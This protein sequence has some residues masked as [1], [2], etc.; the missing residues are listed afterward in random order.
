[1]KRLLVTGVS[2]GVGLEFIKDQLESGNF[3]YGVSRTKSDE[4]NEVS[5]KYP[6]SFHHFL[7]DLESYEELTKEIND[8]LISNKVKLDSFVN[9]AAIA[10]DDIITNANPQK[11]EQMYKVN[12]FAPIMLTKCVIRNFI[13]NKNKG[14]IVHISS[15]S[16]HTGYKG[17]SMYASTKGSLEAFSKSTSR[18]WGVKGIRSNCV[19]AGFMETEMSKSLTEEQKDKIYNRTSLKQSTEIKSVVKTISFLTSD[20]SSSITGQNIFVDSGTI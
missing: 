8:Y 5:L 3:V 13:L 15:I 19:V 10:Y 7:G 20:S 12:V 18:E 1:M 16:V 2:R 4:L 17:L 11:L 14:T 6:N 9:N